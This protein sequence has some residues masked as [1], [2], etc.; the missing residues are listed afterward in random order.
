[1]V[2]NLNVL[3]GSEEFDVDN[4]V[5]LATLN[6]LSELLSSSV[7]SLSSI[8][9]RHIEIIISCLETLFRSDNTPGTFSMSELLNPL[10]TKEFL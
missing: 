9:S 7:A 6:Y 2:C 10:S 3:L 8:D 4:D 5:D 1:M